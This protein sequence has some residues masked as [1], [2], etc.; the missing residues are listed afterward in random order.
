[1]LMSDT[2]PA[3]GEGSSKDATKTRR[4]C[5][6]MP[7]KATS[8]SDVRFRRPSRELVAGGACPTSYPDMNL[9]EGVGTERGRAHSRGARVSEW[10]LLESARVIHTAYPPPY[11]FVGKLSLSPRIGQGKN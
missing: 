6:G 7:R 2:T 5:R 1:M 4:C 9:F 8:I 3:A 11:V 10:Q